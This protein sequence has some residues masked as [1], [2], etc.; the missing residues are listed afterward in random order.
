MH[1]KALDS[2]DPHQLAQFAAWAHEN[3]PAVQYLVHAAG[4]LGFDLIPDLTPSTFKDII[5]PKVG[6]NSHCYI[7][8]FPWVM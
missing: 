2:S 8:L 4:L 1:V 3:L 5:A 6:Q 7:Y